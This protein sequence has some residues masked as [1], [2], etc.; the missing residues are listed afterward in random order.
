MIRGDGDLY[1][2]AGGDW[3]LGLAGFFKFFF[4]LCGWTIFKVFIEFVTIL[5]L[6]YVLDFWPPGMCTLGP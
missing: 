5:L 6:N 4:F 3:P 1:E 2:N